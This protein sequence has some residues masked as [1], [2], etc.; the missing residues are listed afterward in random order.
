MTTPNEE[1]RKLAT[2][3]YHLRV[4]SGRKLIEL[5]DRID[6]LE[7]AMKHMATRAEVE[8]LMAENEAKDRLLEQALKDLVIFN[9]ASRLHGMYWQRKHVDAITQHLKGTP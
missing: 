9:E 1:L 3:N 5:L 6:R 7:A 2:E 4:F 8:T